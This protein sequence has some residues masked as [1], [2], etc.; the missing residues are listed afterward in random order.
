MDDE[1]A[2]NRGHCLT[3]APSPRSRREGPR[4]R[5]SSSG[6]PSTTNIGL[7]MNPSC[8]SHR[9]TPDE[10]RAF[11]SQGFLVVPNALD[12]ATCS[13]L[14]TEVD[15]V[16]AR[17]RTPTF[18]RDKLLS[19]ANILPESDAFVELVDWPRIFPKVWAILG[20]NIYCY[21]T[22]GQQPTHTTWWAYVGVDRAALFAV[23][24]E[25]E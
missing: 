3:D 24:Q 14:V 21:H 11:Q 25:I 9:L 10:R 5:P 19:F 17:E 7:T 2:T 18:G 15:R 12:A 20:W 8:L 22:K 13:R 23:V 6:T 4:R 16:D 1:D